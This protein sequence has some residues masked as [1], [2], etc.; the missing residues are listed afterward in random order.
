MRLR[1]DNEGRMSFIRKIKSPDERLV[2]I[3]Y[4]HWIYGL[5]GILWLAGL[6]LLGLFLENGLTGLF[7]A[8]R[9]NAAWRVV[10]GF[11][12]I[13]FWVCSIIGLVFFF[14]YILM[15]ATTEIGLTDKRVI[16]KRGFLF[17]RTLEVDIEEIK[18]ATV[19]NG[20]LGRILNY[21]YILLD[22][23]FVE[24]VHLPALA[25]PYRF[26]KALNEMRSKQ[27]EAA[28]RLSLDRPTKQEIAQ[29]IQSDIEAREAREE[30]VER[31]EP[32]THLQDERYKALNNNPLDAVND[33]IEDT[34]EE[35]AHATGILR[36]QAE[37]ARNE[38]L[39]R[40]KAQWKAHARKAAGLVKKPA[41]QPAE[42]NGFRVNRNR[43][44]P[45]VLRGMREGFIEE[46]N[47]QT[48]H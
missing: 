20:I 43:R 13:I 27:K 47:E 40:R 12:D 33:L 36:E 23:R 39:P 37:I 25:D 45:I 18:G 30:G 6:M 17:V 9:D 10:S 15:M 41:P 31:K 24:N 14:F 32:K 48:M 38:D 4:I 46:F 19:D 28:V 1:P 11:G 35:A 5:Q 16:Y 34:G 3:A 21:G 42:T 22:A 29:Q 7:A 2:G 26:V 8:F 44:G